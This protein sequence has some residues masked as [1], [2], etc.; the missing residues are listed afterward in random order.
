[1]PIILEIKIYRLN[2][3][4]EFISATKISLTCFSSLNLLSCERNR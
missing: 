1:M 3:K 4:T 2:T